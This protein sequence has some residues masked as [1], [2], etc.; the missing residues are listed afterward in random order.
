MISTSRIN[1]KN[2]SVFSCRKILAMKGKNSRDERLHGEVKD[3][4]AIKLIHNMFVT[5]KNNE[6]LY[7][8]HDSQK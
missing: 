1:V 4:T 5:D 2:H 8:H 6:M 7:H 3:Y